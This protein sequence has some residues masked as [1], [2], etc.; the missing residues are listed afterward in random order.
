MQ[1]QNGFKLQIR[2]RFVVKNKDILKIVKVVLLR[3]LLRCSNTLRYSRYFNFKDKK[4]K[5]TTRKNLTKIWWLIKRLNS[6][7]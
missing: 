4:N 2:N 6:F 3:L 1:I 7:F 5:M